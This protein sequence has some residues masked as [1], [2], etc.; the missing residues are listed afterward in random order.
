MLDFFFLSFLFFLQLSLSRTVKGGGFCFK[1]CFLIPTATFVQCNSTRG[2]CSLWLRFAH[3]SLDHWPALSHSMTA[4]FSPGLKL[5]ICQNSPVSPDLSQ[6]ST[7]FRLLVIT[8]CFWHW[9]ACGLLRLVF[10]TEGDR[11]RNGEEKEYLYTFQT[12]LL[13]L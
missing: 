5:F 7:L 13:L 11:Q 4:D 9:T 8:T 10:L 12:P 6:L 2:L 1:L 3:L